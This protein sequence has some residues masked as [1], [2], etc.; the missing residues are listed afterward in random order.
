MRPLLALT[1][2]LGCT[3][4]PKPGETG[5]TSLPDP[6]ESTPT[7]D[8]TPEDSTHTGAETGADPDPVD[9]DGDGLNAL[10]DCDDGDPSIGAGPENFEGARPGYWDE[11]SGESLG[12]PAL[13][14]L[15]GDGLLDL[16]APAARGILLYRG[17]GT[18]AFEEGELLLVDGGVAALAVGDADAD[19]APDL[20]ALL[21]DTQLAWLYGLGDLD[22]T[23]PVAVE[24]VGCDLPADLVAEDLDSDERPDL[25]ALCSDPLLY[26]ALSGG[27]RVEFI[28]SHGADQLR[29]RDLDEDGDLDLALGGDWALGITLL[30]NDGTGTMDEHAL[31]LKEWSWALALVDVNGDGTLD[32]LGGHG[33]DRALVWFQHD[34]AWG[35]ERL[36]TNWDE[37]LDD[38]APTQ[39][40]PLDVDGDGIEEVVQ[41]DGLYTHTL[42][43]NGD[44][45]SHVEEHSWPMSAS[46]LVAGDLDGDGRDDLL[47]SD[48]E[49][50]VARLGEGDGSLRD[51]VWVALDLANGL[52]VADVD[53]DGLD[54]L[55]TYDEDGVARLYRSTGDSLIAAGTLNGDMTGLDDLLLI[56]LDADGDRDLVTTNYY[57]GLR[58]GF[59]E[60]GEISSRVAWRETMLRAWQLAPLALDEGG[61]DLLLLATWDHVELLLTLQSDEDGALSLVKETEHGLDAQRFAVADVDG[62]GQQDAI[63]GT[64]AAD[65]IELWLGD[66]LGFERADVLVIHGGFVGG[67][68]GDIDEDGQDELLFVSGE[69]STI[70]RLAWDGTAL[71][72]SDLLSTGAA[73][74]PNDFALA[75]LNE[76]GHL[77]LLVD[78]G[79][80]PGPLLALGDGHGGF[81]SAGYLEANMVWGVSAFAPLDIDGDGDQDVAIFG[82][83]QGV[84]ILLNHCKD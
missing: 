71:S 63:V 82:G 55:A 42:E 57:G 21:N 27:A 37:S 25:A 35:F 9:A 2:L 72:S 78:N 58:I 83:N 40:V 47:A 70:Q 50:L 61:G 23:A 3:D 64:N 11:P 24:T 60:D 41:N 39:L 26:L 67:V 15:D 4:L 76:D 45:L 59:V 38:T 7:P 18:G 75:D 52:R 14:D 16:A 80:E 51:R 29:A 49:R 53:G 65:Q 13:A 56:D 43:S 20:G 44:G 81:E 48:G 33:N 34:G 1:A 62:D 79:L 31:T 54:D 22:F 69:H 68:S 8:S 36:A 6:T 32:V 77:D 46:W 73:P 17:L 10:Q 12:R 30:E 66:G 84:N 74:G 19:G 5:E 28:P